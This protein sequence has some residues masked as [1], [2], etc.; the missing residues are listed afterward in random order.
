[1]K[2]SLPFIQGD[3]KNV[4]SL[5]KSQQQVKSDTGMDDFDRNG[6]LCG[7]LLLE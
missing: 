2:Q 1:M 3:V 4:E 5:A 6:L 7:I